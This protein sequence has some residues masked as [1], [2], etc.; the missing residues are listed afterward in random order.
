MADFW[1]KLWVEFWNALH[2]YLARPKGKVAVAVKIGA[3]GYS[4]AAEEQ[5]KRDAIVSD[6]VRQKGDPYDFGAEIPPGIY[7][8]ITGDCS[9]Y[10]EWAFH[11]NG[12]EMPDGSWK[13]FD[14]CRPVTDPLPCD[15]GFL[16]HKKTGKISH[17]VMFIGD[18]EIIHAVGGD[19]RR[20]QIDSADWA[21]DHPRFAGWRR[22][23]Y[24]ARPIEGRA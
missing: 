5:R 15:L 14:Y 17:V 21:Q 3:T 20:V 13:Q 4:R 19:A 2:R 10:V 24:F 8:P 18:G 23:P 11:R 6:F 9:E 22:H 7:N 12:L 16:R 1:K